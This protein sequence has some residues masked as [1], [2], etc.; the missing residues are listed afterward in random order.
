LVQLVLTNRGRDL[1]DQVLESRRRVVSDVLTSLP[2]E[3]QQR[4]A[5][6][7]TDFAMAAGDEPTRDGRFVMALH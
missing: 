4:I 7:L 6:A 1:V 3:E 5:A 2:A